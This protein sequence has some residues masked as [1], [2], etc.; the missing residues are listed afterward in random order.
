MALQQAPHLLIHLPEI[1]V[2]VLQSKSYFS[3]ITADLST[4]GP[5]QTKKERDWAPTTSTLAL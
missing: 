1:F 4:K 3:S 2:I 5:P